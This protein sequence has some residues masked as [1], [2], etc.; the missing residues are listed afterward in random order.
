[1]PKKIAK[2]TAASAL[3]TASTLFALLAIAGFAP[4]T[5]CDAQLE[6][7]DED[8]AFEIEADNEAVAVN[9]VGVPV[10]AS[11]R[12]PGD[13]TVDFLEPEPGVVFLSEHG[14]AAGSPVL[15][16][17]DP[18][19]LDPLDI[20]ELITD[21]EEPPAA[22]V[23]AHE[24]AAGT[25]VATIEDDDDAPLASS[26][27]EVDDAAVGQQP[28]RGIGHGEGSSSGDCSKAWAEQHLSGCSTHWDAETRRFNATGQASIY[29]WSGSFHGT[30]VCPY[31]NNIRFRYY[32]KKNLN[33]SW[34]QVVDT[35]IDEDFYHNIS[36]TRVGRFHSRSRVSNA[37]GDFYQHCTGVNK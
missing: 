8:P 34:L 14:P 3:T 35:P 37:T 10:V 7:G 12:L 5:G 36:H 30:G 28:T 15:A 26:W 2:S 18:Q 17:L 11:V 13:V 9:S 29:G 24:A 1:M 22:L 21:E 31:D 23:R 4:V 20:Y 16:Q 33:H 19:N 32:W 6:P 25:V 27:L